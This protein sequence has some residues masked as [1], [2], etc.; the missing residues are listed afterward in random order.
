MPPKKTVTFEPSVEIYAYISKVH[1]VFAEIIKND[2]KKKKAIL[3]IKNAFK[4]YLDEIKSLDEQNKTKD[5]P[6]IESELSSKNKPIVTMID[7]RIVAY[8]VMLRAISKNESV[9][10]SEYRKIKLEFDVPGWPV[11][12]EDKYLTLWV[13]FIKQATAA[14]KNAMP[15]SDLSTWIPNQTLCDTVTKASTVIADN[16]TANAIIEP[17]SILKKMPLDAVITESSKKVSTSMP[18]DTSSSMPED[19]SSSM[20][21]D[22]S[23]SMPED[24]STSMPEDTSSSTLEDTSISM[25]EDTSS[26]TL[27]DTSTSM[28]EDT[29]TSMLEDTSTSMLED[30]STSMLEDTSTSMLEDTSTSMLED[31]S[32]SMLEDTSTSMLEDTSSFTPEDTSTSMLEDTSTSMPEDTS[33]SMLEDTSTSMPEDTSSFTPEDTSTSMLED[34]SSF[35]PEDTSTPTPEEATTP[36]S[37]DTAA[38]KKNDT[39]EKSTPQKLQ[40]KKKPT[41]RTNISPDDYNFDCW[42]APQELKRLIKQLQVMHGYGLQLKPESPEKSVAA[43]TLSIELYKDLKDFY[44]NNL[45]PSSEDKKKFR[46]DFHEKL[47]SQDELMS[48]HRKW[49]KVIVGNIAVALTGL[50]LIPLGISLLVRGHGFFNETKSQGIIN[51]MDDKLNDCISVK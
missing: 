26:S 38:D 25:P 15:D 3:E 46:D 27:E 50:G 19:T 5:F 37:K 8:F 24:T 29:S 34:T 44:Q 14:F 4:L 16:T 17:Q 2:A 12:P 40:N 22:T 13:N 9:F 51:D 39:A 32:T 18:E 20:P 23:T 10:P 1:H 49:W 47:H 30:T 11:A 28:L 36:S 7:T 41:V 43:M 33:T 6:L 21:E 35:T 31:T 45:M 48:T 42:E